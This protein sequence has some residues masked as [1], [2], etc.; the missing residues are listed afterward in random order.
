MAWWDPISWWEDVTKDTVNV[1]KSV[2]D[3][4]SSWLNGVAGDMASGI[5]GAFAALLGDMFDVVIGPLEII[6]GV[7]IMFI[8]LAWA[9]KNQIIQAGAIAAAAA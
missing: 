6:I 2:F 7:I 3:S 8:V 1:D 5:E 4:A 9:F